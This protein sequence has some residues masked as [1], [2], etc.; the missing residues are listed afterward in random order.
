MSGENAVRKSSH[1]PQ[2]KANLMNRL[3]RIEGQVRGIRGMI[4]KDTYCDD[5]LI[6]ISSVQAA[7]G[8][9]GK[10]LLEKHLECCI[11]GRVRQGDTAVVSEIMRTMNVILK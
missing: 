6:Q 5:V 11:E 7:L 4:E 10:L 9:A 2:T 8:A 1:D 3:N